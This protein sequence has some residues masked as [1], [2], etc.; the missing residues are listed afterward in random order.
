L[1][2]KVRDALS[3]KS[4]VG[5]C[6]LADTVVAK[7]VDAVAPRVPDIVFVQDGPQRSS[8]SGML[9]QR[10]GSVGN[11]NASGATSPLRGS[12]GSGS[13]LGLFS[14]KTTAGDVSPTSV[15]SERK[16]RSPGQA[17]GDFHQVGVFR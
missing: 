5:G 11:S 8:S 12:D 17:G 13:I 6:L 2:G 4:K 1:F 3:N 9:S 14:A 10:K 15:P 16:S 7:G